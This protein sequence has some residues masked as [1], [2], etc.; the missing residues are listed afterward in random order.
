MI[1]EMSPGV[2]RSVVVL[3]LA[4][5]LASVAVAMWYGFQCSD[6]ESRALRDRVNSLEAQ[7]RLLEGKLG[8][9]WLS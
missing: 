5:A 4:V 3:L 7:M 2:F 9:F 1:S 8:E 6:L